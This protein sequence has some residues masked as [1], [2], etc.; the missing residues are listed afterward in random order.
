MAKLELQGRKGTVRFK[1]HLLDG[2]EKVFDEISDRA[3][4]AQFEELVLDLGQTKKITSSGVAKLLTL[5]NLLDH[6]GIRL[7]VVNLQSSLMDVLKKFKVDMM[8][9][10]RS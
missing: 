6:F 2:Y 5:K 3:S 8:L 7:E 10:I 4:R 9:K 1:N